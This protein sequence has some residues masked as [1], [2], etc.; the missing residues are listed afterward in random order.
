MLT[1]KYWGYG[2]SSYHIIRYIAETC[3]TTKEAFVRAL[4]V[5]FY[6]LL[7]LSGIAVEII[8]WLG[9]TGNY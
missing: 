8:A 4:E 1:S 5:E 2:F 3:K 6:L 9:K 7:P